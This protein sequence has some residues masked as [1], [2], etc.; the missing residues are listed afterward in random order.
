MAF[1]FGGQRPTSKDSLREYQRQIASNARGMERE[2][3]RLDLQENALQRDL[4]MCAANNRIDMAVV[5]AKEM[6]RLRAH[7]SRLL[8]MKGHMTGL[9]Q[10]L[11]TVQ[12]TNKIQETIATTARMLQVLNSR[13][14]AVSVARMMAEF[15][16]Q[17]VL[18]ANK[19]EV[20]EDT[21]DCTFEVDGEQEAT[22]DAVLEVLQ[23]V[24]LDVQ[25]K[26]KGPMGK[27]QVLEADTDR[28]EERL[29]RLRPRDG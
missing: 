23:G 24:G 20:I 1:L 7:R 17:N 2:V 28:L 12:S 5:K 3:A 21:L 10:Q 4:A 19:Q 26:L 15:E 9:S 6:V 8:S 11:Q 18:M 13:F 25:S 14:D 22:N 29:Q 27:Q 16:K